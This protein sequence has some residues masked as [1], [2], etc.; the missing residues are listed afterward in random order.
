MKLER[1]VALI[2]GASRGIGAGIARCLAREGASIVVNYFR[3]QEGALQTVRD[4]EALGVKA[5]AIKADVGDYDQV[6]SMVEQ[7]LETF[8]KVDILV[9]NAGIGGPGKP[10]ID[11]TPE[12]FVEVIENHLIGSFN[13]T[14]ALLPHMRQHER[15]DIQFISSR[16]T[17]MYP[18]NHTAYASAKS[19][20]DAFAKVLAK[21][22]RY[23]GI[24]VNA[25][26]PGVVESDMTR[27][28]HSGSDGDPRLEGGGQGNAFWADYAARRYWQLVV[29]SWH[30]Q[31]PVI[32]RER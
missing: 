4:V 2:T 22:E 20:L 24:R 7:S 3:S 16:Q 32:F 5:I 19:G 14:H 13:C 8:A 1:R 31:R 11:T 21:E 12:E 30:P 10:L 15:A 27:E 23:H 9:N 17:D 28:A 6:K 26:A 29:L 25:I 18:P